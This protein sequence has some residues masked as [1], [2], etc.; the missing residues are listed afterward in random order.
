MNT[1]KQFE[2][3]VAFLQANS[4]KKVSTILPDI[5]EMTKAKQQAKNF[6]VDEEGNVTRVYCYYHKVW[7]DVSECEYGA[8]KSS[9]SGLN[10]MCKVGYNQW[11][12][13]QRDFKK[14]KDALLQQVADGEVE[15]SELNTM[16]EDLEAERVAIVP[17]E[18]T[19]QVTELPPE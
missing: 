19:E 13:Q 18:T 11:S 8:K 1:K 17:R 3:V 15:A 12:K 5:L 16:L 9:A 6:E 2:E 4:N 10:S 7:E 14:A